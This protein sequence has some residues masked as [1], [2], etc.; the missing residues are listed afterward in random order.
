MSHCA[1]S[2]MTFF[3][4]S[5]NEK[6]VRERREQR[7]HHREELVVAASVTSRR[8]SWSSS[9]AA[10][11]ASASSTKATRLPRRPRKAR[12]DRHVVEDET[13]GRGSKPRRRIIAMAPLMPTTPRKRDSCL[14]RI[15]FSYFQK[16]PLGAR[17]PRARQFPLASRPAGRRARAPWRGASGWIVAALTSPSSSSSPLASARS[18][19]SAAGFRG[20]A[21]PTRRC[22]RGPRR[23]A[24]PRARHRLAL[25]A[26]A[27]TDQHLEELGR[28]VLRE[29]A[30]E[31][32][33]KVAP[34]R[35]TRREGA[36]ARLRRLVAS[37]GR[38][39]RAHVRQHADCDW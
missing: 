27:V 5:S 29:Q 10:S 19:L 21:R 31:L 37:R 16:M 6:P 32:G 33:V 1:T 22:R 34:P 39:A 11:Y 3:E 2:R 17:R 7:R 4:T 23:A 35:C 14:V 8:N 13:F 15:Q 20:A 38:P 12:R 26:A 28:V 25:V 36:D 18:A 24:R 30:L 9:K